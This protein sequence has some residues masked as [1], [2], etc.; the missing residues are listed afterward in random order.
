RAYTIWQ[1]MPFWK[2]AFRYKKGAVYG[3]LWFIYWQRHIVLVLQFLGTMVL[4]TS[5]TPMLNMWIIDIAALFGLTVLPVK[6]WF[7]FVAL[8]IG[9]YLYVSIFF[10]FLCDSLSKVII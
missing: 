6:D 7:F 2:K 4:F 10:V 5:F 1:R 3:R 9:M 8:A